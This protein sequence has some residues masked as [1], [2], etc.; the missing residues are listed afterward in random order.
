MLLRKR[1]TEASKRRRI[2]IS[3]QLVV[4][5]FA[6]SCCGKMENPESGEQTLFT[7]M[8]ST[9]ITFRNDV[10]DTKDDNSF[11][12]RNFYNGG[13]VA[14]GDINNDGLPDVLLTSNQGDNKLYLNKGSFKFQDI[15]T[16]S[17]LRQDSMWSTGATMVDIN[18]D[19]W[20]DVYVCNSG[21]IKDG[22]RRNK[23]YIN[24]H[25]LTFTE[26]AASFGLDVSGF[27][28]QASFFDYDLDG[29]LDCFIINNSP[30]PFS[31]LNYGGMRDVDISQWKGDEKLKGGGNHL[32]QNN[33]IASSS[34]GG[35]GQIH[36]TEVTKQAGLH[37]GLISFG[38]GVTV[39]DINEDGYP[40]IYVGNDFIEKDYLYINQKN[41][42]FK[43]ELEDH[44]QKISMSSMSADVADMNNDG[45][46]D[47]F[48]TDMI[49]DNDYRLK[50]T[51]TFDNVDLYLSKQKAGL[52][53]Q[54]VRNCLQ[55]NN[56][57]GTFSEIGNYCGV[58]GTDWSWGAVFMDADNDG[59]NDLFVCNGIAKDLGDLDFL[60]FFSNDVY[61]NM[62]ATGQRMEMDELL[63][64]IPS[65][66]LPN[67]IFRNRGDLQFEDIGKK[68]GFAKPTFSN[69]IAYADLDG[70]GNL[71]IVINNE[72]ST[73]TVY[74][75]NGNKAQPANNYMAIQLKAKGAN[76]FAVGSKIKLY[77]H[78]EIISR[79]IF[80]VRGFQSSMDYRQIIGIGKNKTIDSIVVVW[81]D[82]SYINIYN[83]TLNKLLVIEKDTK[84]KNTYPDAMPAQPMFQQ[85][86][87]P[88]DKHK[89]DDYVDFY[90]E[91]NLP[92]MLSREG[93]H[94]AKGDVNGDGLED[95]Y[96]GGAKDQPGQLYLQDRNGHF[97]KKEEQVFNIYQ[98][99][100]DVA[101]LFF[102]ADKDGDLD[103]FIGGGGNN[104]RPGEREIQ[105]RLYINDGKGNFSIYIKAFPINDANISVAVA[106]DFD[107]DGDLDLFVGGRSQPYN[108]GFIP[109]SYIYEN[110]GKGN[111]IDV[112]E[113]LSN[114]IAH[115]GMVTGA[116]WADMSGDARKEL[117][118]TGE[119]MP[120]RIFSF[121]NKKMEEVK[122]TGLEKLF[123]WWQTIAAADVDGDGKQDLIIGNIGENFYLRPTMQKPVKLWVG[124]FDH[125]S[126]TEQF[127]TQTVDGKDMPVFLK[128]EE[129]EQFPS[130]KK[131]NLRHSQYASKSIENLFDKVT[132]NAVGQLQFNYC[133]SIVA[134]SN[135]KGH[136]TLKLLP[137]RTQMSSINAICTT[138]FNN[139][140]KYDLLLGGNLFT[141]PP[142]FGRL[143]ASYGNVL[144]NTG[145]DDFKWMGNNVTGINVKGE[146]KD[147]KEVIVKGKRQYLFTQN[148]G[149]PVMYQLGK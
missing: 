80:P 63:K 2:K 33:S 54:Y 124:D 100:E 123:G 90:N 22:N 35:K 50:T 7:E 82:R 40:D 19:G 84:I 92:E 147:I 51:G 105:H 145:N 136:F 133:S 31:S 13:G 23:L 88:F 95:I 1:G 4:L 81:P 77:L 69:S 143:D 121:S 139:D 10:K 29:D 64:H 115:I 127:L 16:T 3:L 126:S 52:Y 102:D 112:T 89:E 8:D 120:T 96:I 9:G 6:C 36:F 87:V 28:T 37:S 106:D 18:A 99:F 26:S 21:H 137:V 79:E 59:Y 138:D 60:D 129:T 62:M 74:R 122:N 75:N 110:D 68:W 117:I 12:F 30:I 48:T 27:C 130:L 107:G 65:N 61:A 135:G 25:D 53:H 101:L 44:I 104:V 142:Q 32:F 114:N 15:S 46:P 149:F 146:T 55:L 71:D 132:L 144:L 72:N 83:P 47:I 116:V 141:F 97:T 78:N 113:S 24:N 73:A 98:S 131:Q 34:K 108:Y 148:D 43:D 118:I 17:G 134:L 70:D 41:G 5:A 119:W 125:N 20:L 67:R 58:Y 45:H 86:E 38:L 39:S 93:P 128:R 11:L 76:T 49:P 103:L 66:P 42:T 14:L 91:R 94:I 111:F 56:G 109:R 85:V 57:N 140:G